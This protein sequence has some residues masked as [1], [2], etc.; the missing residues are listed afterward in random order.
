M[1]YC[2]QSDTQ[3]LTI[4][5][6]NVWGIKGYINSIT[7]F[8]YKHNIDFMYWKK[9]ISMIFPKSLWFQATITLPERGMGIIIY[10]KAKWIL[11]YKEIELDLNQLEIFGGFRILAINFELWYC[12]IGVYAPCS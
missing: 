11:E 3:Q 6:A 4:G 7:S 10:F 8:I 2:E 5:Q 9:Y 12:I 1:E